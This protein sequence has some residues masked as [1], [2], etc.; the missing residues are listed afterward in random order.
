MTVKSQ[1]TP[2]LSHVDQAIENLMATL[3]SLPLMKSDLIFAVK[4]SGAPYLYVKDQ[5]FVGPDRH[6]ADW[7]VNWDAKQAKAAATQMVMDGERSCNWNQCECKS[8]RGRF[9]PRF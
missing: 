8:P 1:S 2:V 5:L 4:E 6:N 9:Q 7:V 3:A